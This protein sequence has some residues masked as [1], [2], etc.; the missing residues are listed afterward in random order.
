MKKNKRASP[1]TIQD[2]IPM[3]NKSYLQEWFKR[4]GFNH[5]KGDSHPGNHSDG[6]HSLAA[7]LLAEI[8]CAAAQAEDLT[9]AQ[10]AKDWL[11]SPAAE[12]MFEECNINYKGLSTWLAAGC[13]LPQDASVLDPEARQPL[14]YRGI[15]FG[16]LALE[17]YDPIY[18]EDIRDI[19]NEISD[20]PF[21]TDLNQ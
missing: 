11:M 2:P 8:V 7:L 18:P 3:G 14:D 19:L 9:L 6:W 16:R 17:G 12:L 5:P 10:E 4:M 21:F 15:T 20:S 13:P 1:G